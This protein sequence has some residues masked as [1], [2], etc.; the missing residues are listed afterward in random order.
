MGRKGICRSAVICMG[1]AL[2]LFCAP[3]RASDLELG[4]APS[5]PRYANTSEGLKQF[6]RD[7][8][9]A[10]KSGDKSKLDTFM[11]E[12]SILHAYDWFVA[13]YGEEDIASRIQD[14]GD[15]VGGNEADVRESLARIGRA[16][17]EIITRS[18]NEHHEPGNEIEQE[19]LRRLK[20]PT[21]FYYAG[22]TRPGAA[23]TEK[24][25]VIGYFVFVTGKFRIAR[26]HQR[27]GIIRASRNPETGV[28][29]LVL[30]KV[31]NPS[32]S[33]TK[34]TNPRGNFTLELPPGWTINSELA[35][36]PMAIGAVSDPDGLVNLLIQMA[37]A[38]ERP[39]EFLRAFDAKGPTMFEEY[40]KVAMSDMTID[41][42]EAAAI[43]IISTD[44][45]TKILGIALPRTV[46]WFFVVVR[47]RDNDI[48]FNFVTT[49]SAFGTMEA[50]FRRIINSFRV[51]EN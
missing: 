38:Q 10:A 9:A 33:G 14:Y 29:E 21:S 48:S 13:T 7:G 16:D 50:T 4:Q 23:A 28:L 5:T 27:S 2:V 22:W 24:S 11:R 3:T 30:P 26:V 45:Q 35:K 40:R 12:T 1:M 34:Y 47:V 31:A 19:M 17:G 15:N 32:I 51:D 37:P 18:V 8:V 20:R 44:R 42:E 46:E 6:L 36:A 41:G 43:T 25:E 39:A 49:E